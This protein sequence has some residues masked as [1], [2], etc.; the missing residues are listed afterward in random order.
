MNLSIRL[1][2]LVLAL[3]FFILKGFSVPAGRIDFMNLGFA[4]LV[5]AFLFG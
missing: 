2:F 1:V 5:A 3:I 4:A